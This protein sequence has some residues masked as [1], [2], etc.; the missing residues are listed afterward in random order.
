MF[1]CLLILATVAAAAPSSQQD[2]KT[3]AVPLS[4]KYGNYPRITADLHWG[5]PAQNPVEAIVDTGS[6]GFWVYGPNSIIN[7][8]S[9]LLFQQGPC[10]KSVKNLYDYRTSS[11]KKARKTADLAYAYRGNGKI[12]AGGYT[13]NDTFSF[14]NKKWPA[15]NNRR[16]GIV[17]FTLV[18]QLDEGC[19]IPESTFDHSILGL[20]APK[21]G[22]AGMSP[23]FRN[24][25]KA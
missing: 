15:L 3:Y 11:S 10:N 16:V 7:D 19:K 24:D 23:S 21:K 12:A 5:T 4:F 2:V 14:A 13:I 25:L 6:A 9:N 22:L 18:R 1:S 17:N 20:A 8:G